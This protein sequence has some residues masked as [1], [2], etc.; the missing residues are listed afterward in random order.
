MRTNGRIFEAMI[1]VASRA[2]GL[3]AALTVSS[4]RTAGSSA[5]VVGPSSRANGATAV[6][7]R[8]RLLQRRRELADGV[9][10][11]IVL[12]GERAQRARRPGDE[13][14]EVLR[15]LGELAVDLCQRRDEAAQR[16]A[17]RG[18]LLADAAEVAHRRA[19]AL[20]HAR[21]RVPLPRRPSPA[22]LASSVR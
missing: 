3:T 17:L 15:A 10:Q 19:V 14:R 6:E 13:P 11:A 20:E 1:G 4:S 12:A 8:R 22:P 2:N 9:A 5:R 16:D 7:R 21:E 18:D